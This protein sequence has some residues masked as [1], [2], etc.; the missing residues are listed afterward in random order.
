MRKLLLSKILF[1]VFITTGCVVC[2]PKGTQ[3]N[4]AVIIHSAEVF[5]SGTGGYGSYRIPAIVKSN[6]GGL[7]AFIEGRVNGSNDF[8]NIDILMKKSMDG[9]KTWSAA[10]IVADNGNLQAG[11][12]CPIVDNTDPAYPQGRI[13][14]FY[15]TGNNTESN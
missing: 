12:A 2:I 15:C 11:N 9:G 1:A 14:L 4:T 10:K 3:P 7:L 8:G 13:F 5:T 6:D